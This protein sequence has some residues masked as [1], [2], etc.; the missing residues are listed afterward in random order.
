MKRVF[1]IGA[2]GT[3]GQATVRALVHAGHEVVCFLRPRHGAQ[4]ALVAQL[5]SL[6]AEIRLGDV[7]DAVVHRDHLVLTAAEP[8]R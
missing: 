4:S 3:I 6:G 7:G 5:Q 2:S 8:P 1:M